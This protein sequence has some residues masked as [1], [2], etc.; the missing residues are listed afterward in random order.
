M[1][2]LKTSRSVT[3]PPEPDPVPLL[4]YLT[5][6]LSLEVMTKVPLK[7][8]PPTTPC[9][10]MSSP[11]ANVCAVVVVSVTVVP[12]RVAVEMLRVRSAP[13]GSF[14]ISPT[15]VAARSKLQSLLCESQFHW[16][17]T[18]TVT[19][20]PLASGTIVP[21]IVPRIGLPASPNAL[22]T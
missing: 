1:N 10:R 12:L 5:C 15:P 8:V 13:L 4:V 6:V 14:Q 19:P 11:T 3:V 20:E 17:R 18:Y 22:A 9:T 21:L 7:P 2:P 16:P